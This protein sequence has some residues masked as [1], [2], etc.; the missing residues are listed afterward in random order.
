MQAYI[1]WNEYNYIERSFGKII[2]INS[3]RTNS[4]RVHKQTICSL[5]SKRIYCKPDNQSFLNLILYEMKHR[6]QK[7]C[8]VTSFCISWQTRTK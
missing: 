1:L 5:Y 2:K 8:A 4:H 6:Q 7:C 3:F